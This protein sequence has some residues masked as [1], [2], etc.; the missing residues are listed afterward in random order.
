[1]SENAAD[2]PA[3][4]PPPTGMRRYAYQGRIGQG[5]YGVVYKAT[6]V[7][8]QTTVALKKIALL[9]VDEGVPSTAIREISL[10]KDLC[11]DHIVDLFDVIYS[12]NKLFLVF[13]FCEQD[14]KQFM[15]GIVRKNDFMEQALVRKLSHQM[16]QGIAF[17]HENRVL[18]RD[19]KP[20]NVLLDKDMN[21]KLADFG[22]ARAFSV[23]VRK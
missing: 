2:A 1:M 6:D 20:Q 10:L 12:D 13:A 4:P 9:D 3:P 23:P 17:C 8:T 7:V 21:I 19:L 16:L 14:L 22:L 18:H 15:D 5:T 11:H